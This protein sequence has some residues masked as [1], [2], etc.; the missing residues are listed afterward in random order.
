MRKLTKQQVEAIP[1]LLK[2][3]L[4]A[5]QIATRYNVHP[6]TV[7]YWKRQLRLNGVILDVPMGPPRTLNKK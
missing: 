6:T 5:P 7:D 1:D 3:G 4:T 2:E